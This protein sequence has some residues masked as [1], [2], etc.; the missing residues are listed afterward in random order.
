MTSEDDRRLL[1]TL[2]RESIAAH[3]GGR[4]APAPAMTGVMARRGGAFV[5][6]H[7]HGELRGCIGHVEAD[8][9]LGHVIP[10]MA[11]AACSSDPPFPSVTEREL[12][13][14]DLEISLLGP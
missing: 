6:I 5:T 9:V 4:P 11:L 8:D 12:P 13:Q 2:A 1:L 7:N 10:R 14:L 3:V